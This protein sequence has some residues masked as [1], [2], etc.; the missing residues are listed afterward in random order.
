[1]R[2]HIPACCY[3]HKNLKVTFPQ[4]KTSLSNRHRNRTV[5]FSPAN[6]QSLHPVVAAALSGKQPR[7]SSAIPTTS[8]RSKTPKDRARYNNCVAA[9]PT[10]TRR[11]RMQTAHVITLRVCGRG[12]APDGWIQITV[13]AARESMRNNRNIFSKDTIDKH[14]PATN[15]PK[16]LIRQF[17]AT[18]PMAPMHADIFTLMNSRKPKE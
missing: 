7:L 14:L 6:H 8:A 18:R 3:R 1:M 11:N 12:G 9:A 13:P 15:A 16:T 4:K 10:M 17:E 5:R 2:S